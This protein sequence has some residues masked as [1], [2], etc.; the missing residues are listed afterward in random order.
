[1][2]GFVL[3]V[4]EER[5]AWL[6][7]WHGGDIHWLGLK[8][9]WRK[10]S[11]RLDWVTDGD[12]IKARRR[13]SENVEKGSCGEA[14]SAH[15]NEQQHSCRRLIVKY[16]ILTSTEEWAAWL[17]HS[18]KAS[19]R[20]MKLWRRNKMISFVL[21]PFHFATFWNLIIKK[22][23]KPTNSGLF[24]TKLFISFTFK[25]NATEHNINNTHC[26]G[27]FYSSLTFWESLFTFS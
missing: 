1:M 11:V 22:N 20:H 6:L 15:L 18:Q 23:I 13:Q 25:K 2:V 5:S 19:R 24:S 12:G 8:T 27:I 9:Y 3:R 21:L 26:V 14:S 10:A 4:S 17:M 7:F 16:S